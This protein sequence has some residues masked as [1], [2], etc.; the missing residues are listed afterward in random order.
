MAKV[1]FLLVISLGVNLSC[2]VQSQTPLFR[3]A[4]GSPFA[5]G[6]QPGDVILGDVN[7]DGN[8]DIVTA[9][10]GSN[11]LTV[12]L[13]D[14]AGNFRDSSP[15]SF[16]TEMAPHLIAHGDFNGDGRL[17]LAI[18]GHATNDVAIL[19]GDEGSGFA[20]ARGSPVAAL[21]RNPPHNHGLAL[22]D[23]N[24][25]GNLDIATTN[26]NDNSVSVLLGDGNGRFTPAPNSPFSV[27]R[28][29]YLL[30]LGDLN[31]D[32]LL[33]L[34]APNFR[35]SNVTALLG[36]GQ[37]G[38]TA[39]S[40][41]P[42]SVAALPYSATLGDLDGD[43]DD[44]LITAHDDSSLVSVMLNDGRGGFRKASG[45]PF[46]LGRRGWKIRL[47]DTNAD[48]YSDMVT[49][50]AGDSV[51]VLLGD[52]KGGFKPAPGSPFAVGGGPWGVALGDVNRDGKLDIVTA[53]SA[54]NNV[55]VLLGNP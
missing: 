27:G 26:Q 34:A 38:F 13:G 30:T 29:P 2:M 45:S 49:G 21:Q 46:D 50:T 51:V 16:P 37:G 40:G 48:G 17:D 12:L 22:G 25:D 5:V 3:S 31:G 39:A 9:N 4:P 19:L 41:S 55:T 54:S 14:G 11:D 1:L 36:N 28:M 44:D 42:Y 8:M 15:Y 24:E 10:A 47:G 33:D 53:N 6:N 18:T 32:N 52:G 43:Q 7:R 23:V 35:D 20:P